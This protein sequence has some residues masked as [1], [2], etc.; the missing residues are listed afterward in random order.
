MELPGF[1][2]MG[3][4]ERH[5]QKEMNDAFGSSI[6]RLFKDKKDLE[7]KCQSHEV[8]IQE[9]E[10]QFMIMYGRWQAMVSV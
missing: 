8:R 2:E 9:L 6:R 3:F 5:S 7:K 1:E 10:D 4:K